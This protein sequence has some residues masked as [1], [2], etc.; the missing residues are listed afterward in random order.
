MKENL[1]EL[2]NKFNLSSERKLKEK[3]K[4]LDRMIVIIFEDNGAYHIHL[5]KGKLSDVEDGK[6]PCDIQVSTTTST[7]K[8]ILSKEE[9]AL[10]AYL[11]KKIK[12]KAKL[13][14]K[15]LISEILR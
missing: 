6:V 11:S 1:Q 4:G 7:F 5:K 14:D 8:R 3:I 15:I 12:V 10:T 9:D 13:M 2:V